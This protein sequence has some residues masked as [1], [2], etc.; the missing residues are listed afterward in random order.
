VLLFQSSISHEFLS[1]GLNFN[2]LLQLEEWSDGAEKQQPAFGFVVCS[3]EVLE[4][5]AQPS[6]RKVV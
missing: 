1:V 4:K 2:H 3:D 5:P 6:S